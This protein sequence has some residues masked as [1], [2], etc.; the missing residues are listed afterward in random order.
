VECGGCTAC[1]DALE[2]KDII[3]VKPAGIKCPHSCD[4]GCSIYDNR[5]QG[6]RGFDCVYLL[7]QD[8]PLELRPD[9]TG[10]IFEKVTT[11]IFLALIKAESLETWDTPLIRQY[12]KQLNNK[13]ISVVVS[14][15]DKGLM[16]VHTAAAHTPDK[17]VQITMRLA[18]QWQHHRTQQT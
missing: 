13:G 2:V 3:L 17:V 9:K 10:V 15:Y 8:S 7:E 5:P 18:N 16:E 4:I 14:S 12:I 6:C 1:C 11:K